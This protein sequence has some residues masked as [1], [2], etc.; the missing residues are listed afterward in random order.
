MEGFHRGYSAI[1]VLAPFGLSLTLSILQWTM[2]KLAAR[3]PQEIKH[4]LTHNLDFFGS[5]KSTQMSFA[6]YADYM[7]EAN[8]ETPLYVFDA[9]MG[10]KMPELLGDYNVDDLRFFQEDMLS[11]MTKNL[12]EK[13]QNGAA[14]EARTM[15]YAAP[16]PN[17]PDFRWIVI[18]P[19]RSG[20]P[21]HTD[22]ARTSA[23]NA[24]VKG[25]KRWALYPPNCPPPGI[26]V[27]KNAYGRQ[28]ALG[29]TSLYWYLHVYPT[30][31]PHERPYEVIQEEGET[32]Y[33]PTGWWHL[34]LNLEETIAVTQNFVD[35]HNFMPFLEDLLGDQQDDSVHRLQSALCVSRPETKDIFRLALMGRT[36][37]YLSQSL[38]LSSFGIL[39][40]W[41]SPI[42]KILTRYQARTQK[43]S[44]GDDAA[45]V[46]LSVLKNKRVPRMKMVTSRAN[47]T[48]AVGQKL[49]IKFFS[50]LNL[51]WNE[52]DFSTFLAPNFQATDSD[53]PE[54]E[55]SSKR[56][57]HAYMQPHELRQN[58]SLR[59]AIE[60]CYRIESSTYKMITAAVFN[61]QNAF[62]EPLLSWIPKFYDHGHV[63]HVDDVD[64]EDGE[65]RFW[66]W[67]YVVI[68]Y[69]RGFVGLD[70]LESSRGGGATQESWLQAAKWISEDFLP[71]LHAVPI[72]PA[73]RGIYGQAKADWDWYLHY[74]TYQRKR[75]IACKLMMML[76][77]VCLLWLIDWHF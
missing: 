58:M 8:D 53:A 12:K 33:V 30:L 54:A 19:Q 75:A 70:K 18:G 46:L 62:L 5:E 73:F 21:W 24:L 26:S 3:F 16:R 48:I 71:R 49:I 9:R 17:R 77:V 65:G 60:E 59:D 63:H 25:R 67:P 4:R 22:P 45:E 31:Q 29:M 23:W 66:R 44:S 47:P 61:G 32:I 20:A 50:Q 39:E 7:R 42:K 36:Q 55:P 34:V 27:G 13:E 38:Y 51:M 74:L 6:D 57:K 43:K 2:E 52:F 56:A 37:G 14:E 11:V 35:P 76:H 68:E 10:E 69:K 28:H 41:K 64:D 72:D 40:Y 15:K 1:V